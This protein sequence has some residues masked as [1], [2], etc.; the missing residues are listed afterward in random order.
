MTSIALVFVSTTFAQNKM[1]DQANFDK[2]FS[3][4]TAQV[5]GVKIHYVIGGKGEPL[6]LLHGWCFTWATWK[7]VMPALAEKYTVIAPDMRG[8][9]ES[10]RPDA[11][12][13]YLKHVV[14]EDI[15]QLTQQLGYKQINLVGH[16]IGMMVAYSYAAAHPKEVKRLI[17]AETSGV[18]GFGFE[19]SWDTANGGY[20]HFAFHG[21]PLAEELTKGKERYYIEKS[22]R[23][24]F[25]KPER[26]TQD[27][28]DV[29]V[30]AYS[31]PGGM[32][33]GFAHYKALLADGKYNRANFKAKLPM[34][35]L[36]LNG[37]HGV[38]QHWLLD[39]TKRV[40]TN[41]SSGFILDSGHSF[42]E[43]NPKDTARQLLAFFGEN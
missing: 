28:M 39:S 9:G 18:P 36:V 16:D 32:R 17:L 8:M 33:G 14:A 6:V 1:K 23:Q 38:P 20:Y 3:H 10:E 19:D 27:E 24:S 15:Y 26:I 21:D 2:T 5:N 4:R 43:E 29:Y 31:Q 40:A 42:M 7:K 41:V 25:Y 37:D 35:V 13:G 22:V 11:P 30:K 34:P 12:E